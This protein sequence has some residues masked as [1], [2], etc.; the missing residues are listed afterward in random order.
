MAGNPAKLAHFNHEKP[1]VLTTDAST[2]DVGTCL[3]HKEIIQGKVYLNPIAYASISLKASEKNYSQ[4]DREGLAI[5]WA[6]LHF[7]QFL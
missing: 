7:K 5:V 6:I 1:L 4:V 2:S 3:A